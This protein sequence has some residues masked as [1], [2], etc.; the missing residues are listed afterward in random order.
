MSTVL[1]GRRILIVEDEFMIAML[2]EDMLTELECVVA[3]VA[4]KPAEALELINSTEVD[5]AV[6]D[7]NLDGTDSFGVAAALGE[8]QIPFVFATGYGGSRLT[9]EFAHYPVIQKPYRTHDLS[10]ALQCSIQRRN[11]SMERGCERGPA[12]I[13]HKLPGSPAID[14]LGS[15]D[16]S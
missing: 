11:P 15:N 16:R 12:E 4:A 8:C 1:A 14:A 7:V 10:A 2:L 9:P 6:L 3:G 5:A 13:G